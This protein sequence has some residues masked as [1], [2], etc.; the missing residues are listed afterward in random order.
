MILGLEGYCKQSACLISLPF[1]YQRCNIGPCKAIFL[2]WEISICTSITCA[3]NALYWMLSKSSFPES[4]ASFV[5]VELKANVPLKNAATFVGMPYYSS[6][7]LEPIFMCT[8]FA[9]I[10]SQSSKA[11]LMLWMNASVDSIH[12]S[13]STDNTLS[14]I[15]SVFVTMVFSTVGRFLEHWLF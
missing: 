1:A 9:K 8:S 15:L 3:T 11:K 12:K 2:L 5:P 4:L 6:R 13:S 14:G 10:V 7:C